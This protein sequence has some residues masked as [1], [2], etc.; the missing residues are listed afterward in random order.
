MEY[1]IITALWVLFCLQQG[2]NDARHFAHSGGHYI[3]QQSYKYGYNIHSSLLLGRII[4]FISFLILTFL[5]GG[6]LGFGEVVPLGIG[7]MALFPFFHEG[8]YYSSRKR[9]DN[10][11]G[12]M[13]HLELWFNYS[14]PTSTAKINYPGWVR[15]VVLFGGIFALLTL[16]K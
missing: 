10:P 9:M 14:S 15:A 7:L 8:S 11:Y 4:V 6:N 2:W 5:K 12:N 1:L 13:S 3:K 16:I